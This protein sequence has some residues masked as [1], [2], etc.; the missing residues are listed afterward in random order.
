MKNLFKMLFDEMGR[1]KRLCSEFGGDLHSYRKAS[2]KAMPNILVVIQNYAGFIESY[3]DYESQVAVLSREGSKYGLTFL[4]TAVNTNAIRYR[5][6]QNFGQLVT[7]QLNDKSEYSAV[8][9]ATGGVQPSPVK[10]RGL[11]REGQSL[12]EFQSASVG[13]EDSAGFIREFCQKA[14][15]D[16]KG[17]RAPRVP[18]L[19]EQVTFSFV[20]SAIDGKNLV[21]P[22]GVE[23]DS[24]QLSLLKVGAKPIHYLLSQSGQTPFTRALASLI[25][26]EL[27]GRMTVMD[28][29]GELS[30]CCESYCSGGEKLTAMV[31]EIFQELVYRHNHA[32]EL[33]DAGKPAPSYEARIYLVNGMADMLNQLTADAQDKLHVLLDKCTS[34]LGIFFILADGITSLSTY[35]Y[36]PW[37]K[38][39]GTLDSGIWAGDGIGEQFLMKV[40]SSQSLY[41]QI[42]QE[43]GYMAIEGRAVLVKLLTV[44]E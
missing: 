37:F 42:G 5:T 34:A 35:S 19:P 20:E 13:G 43:F 26:R 32:K 22:I 38:K 44:E 36:R 2:G 1:R 39:Q 8:F 27:K 7:M 10:G 17:Q 11:Y 9:G 14:A 30:G 12:Y 31:V 15:A 23:R 6:L 33:A 40:K 41:E 29:S 16:W 3:D 28:G 21:F 18:I 4:L 25:A 24:L